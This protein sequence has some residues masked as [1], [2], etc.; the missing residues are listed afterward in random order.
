LLSSLSQPHA[1][2]RQNIVHNAIEDT[3]VYQNAPL[4]P[5]LLEEKIINVIPDGIL[6]I[7]VILPADFSSTLDNLTDPKSNIGS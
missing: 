5:Q 4:S 3:G 6:H 1:R 2:R 7:T